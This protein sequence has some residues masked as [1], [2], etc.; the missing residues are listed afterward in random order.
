MGAWGVGAFENDTAA[1]WD[2]E[3]ETADMAAGLRL[4]TDALALAARTS[5]SAW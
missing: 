4:I 3:F 5:V 1:D 2:L